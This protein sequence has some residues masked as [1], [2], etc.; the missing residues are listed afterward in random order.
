MTFSGRLGEV[1]FSYNTFSETVLMFEKPCSKQVSFTD[2]ASAKP[3]RMN[4]MHAMW[5]LQQISYRYGSHKRT[6]NNVFSFETSGKYSKLYRI[7]SNLIRTPF[8]QPCS[9][10]TARTPALSFGQTP[11]L[12]RE[13]NPHSILIHICMFSPLQ[14]ENGCGLDSRIYGTSTS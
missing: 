7:F 11:A 13:P 6:P 8:L 4:A 1:L 5:H 2:V 9:I 3:Q 14:L 12:D 10:L